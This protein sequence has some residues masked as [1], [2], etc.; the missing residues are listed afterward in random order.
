[1][2]ILIEKWMR[3]FLSN[4]MFARVYVLANTVLRLVGWPSDTRTA[5]HLVDGGGRW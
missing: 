2:C 1:M 4:E 5:G 3:R